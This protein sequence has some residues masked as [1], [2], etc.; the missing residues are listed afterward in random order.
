MDTPIQAAVPQ[1]P[2]AKKTVIKLDP[3]RPYGTE[4]GDRTPDDPMVRVRFWQGGLPFDAHGALVDDNGQRQPFSGP[5]DADGKIP[6]FSPLYDDARAALLA[7]KRDRMARHI[8]DPEPEIVTVEDEEDLKGQAADEVNLAMYLKG[9]AQY[10]P[11]L[12]F[13][14]VERRYHAKHNKLGD[15]IVFLVLDLTGDQ[16]IIDESDLAP[17]FARYLKPY[18]KQVA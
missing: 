1:A 11:W 4:H 18:Q 2:V 5:Q 12:L 15:M 9:E 6:R 16:K 10:E 3:S 8:K 7:K 13:K 14:A 17:E